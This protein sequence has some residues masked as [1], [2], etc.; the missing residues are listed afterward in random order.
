MQILD[1]LG[2]YFDAVVLEAKIFLLLF[3]LTLAILWPQK[4][5]LEIPPFSLLNLW[6][7][8]FVLINRFYWNYDRKFYEPDFADEK[9]I[10][11][12]SSKKMFILFLILGFE[13]DACGFF[14]KTVIIFASSFLSQVFYQS[15]FL[16]IFQCFRYIA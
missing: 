4:C 11:K 2:M 10:T 14:T 8:E 15:V 6:I 16:C 12:N 5:F 7:L 1:L 13:M 9:L 3:R